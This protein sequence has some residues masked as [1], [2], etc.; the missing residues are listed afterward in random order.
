LIRRLRRLAPGF[1]LL[2]R[3]FERLFS[4]ERLPRTFQALRHR[5]FRLFWFGQLISLIGTWMQM[6]A[7]SW[8][9]LDLTK[10]AFM[11]GLVSALGTLP[12]LLF[13]LPAGAIADRVNKRN[14]LIITQSSMMV[15]AFI[16]AV[17]TS[18]RLVQVWHVICLATL[19]GIANAFDMPGRQSFVIEMVGRESLLNAIALNSSAFNSARILGPA[20]AGVLIGTVGVAGCFY[21]NGASFIAVIVGLALMRISFEPKTGASESI[22][23]DML[24]GLRYIG[25]NREVLILISM[26]GI[27]SVFGMP[28]AMLMPVFAKSILMA[29][30]K[31]YGILMS[32]TGIGALAGAL[33]LAT[34][35]DFRHKGRFVLIGSVVFVVFLDLFAVSRLLWLSAA[36]LAV[37][38]FSMVAQAATTNSLLQT[39]APDH[40][41]GRVMA[42]FGVMFMGLAPIGSLQ[43]GS[44]AQ[45]LGAP[46]ALIIGSA[47]IALTL[48]VVLIFR[49]EVKNL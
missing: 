18:T 25:K 35:G 42:V 6:I 12:V 49:P 7:Q 1:S 23:T 48:A 3:F 17:L 46:I 40:L 36:L 32:A 41:R 37:V 34:L 8:L 38:G 28:Y 16:L 20:I 26:V 5:N 30:P 9:V 10:S 19:L 4:P 39:L 14:L 43:A 24:D 11:L 13:S 22:F 2:E 21:V 45:K 15:L 29:G 44:V 33:T 27:F 31:G 47:A